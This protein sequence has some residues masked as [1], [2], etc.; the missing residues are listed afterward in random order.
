MRKLFI[1]YILFCITSVFAQGNSIFSGIET[2]YEMQISASDGQTPLWLNANKYGLSSIKSSNGFIR[3][4]IFRNIVNDADKKWGLGYGLDLAVAYNYQSPVLLQQ[5]Y[6]EGRYKRGTLSI[7]SKYRPMEMK[8]QSL[9]SG[10]QCL[11]INARP[12]PQVRIALE[13]YWAIPGLHDWLSIKGHL[14]YGWMTDG[15]W[16]KDFTAQQ[17][18]WTESALYHSKAGYLKIGKDDKPFSVELGLEMAA[19]FGGKVNWFDGN[20]QFISFDG[21]SG[22]KGYW[23]ALIPGGSDFQEDEIGYVNSEGNHVGSW[24]AKFK[25]SFHTFDIAFYGEHFF[26]DHSAFYHLG[27]YGYGVDGDWQKSSRRYYL[28]PVKDGL[29]GMELNFKYAYYLNSF[30]AEFMNTRFQ[31]GPIYHDHSETIYDQIGGQ[32]NYY[33]HMYYAG[34]QYYGQVIGNPLYL[35]PINNN[36]GTLTIKNNRFYAWHFGFDGNVCQNLTYRILTTW[37]TGLGTYHDPYD[38]P[39]N[40]FSLLAEFQYDFSKLLEGLNMK[41]SYG[42]DEGQILGTNN[43]VQISIVYKR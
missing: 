28:Y 15:S 43:G 4:A 26:E 37:Q 42:H 1:I 22:I 32:D 16:Q 40:N 29:L 31:S 33:N 39:R 35:S 19:I 41:L 17:S 14:A 6:V 13:D 30:V 21:E 18:K 11:G 5:L 25:Y 34:W 12:I 2:E 36:D 38:E 8:N 3:G 20:N 7:G 23:H 10:S 24:L 27:K 9:S